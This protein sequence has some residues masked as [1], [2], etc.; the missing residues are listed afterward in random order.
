M[1]HECCAVICNGAQAPSSWG[2]APRI[3]FRI[4][5]SISDESERQNR[6]VV[7]LSPQENLSEVDPP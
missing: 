2:I 5:G 1:T 6:F 3:K 4:F 7:Q